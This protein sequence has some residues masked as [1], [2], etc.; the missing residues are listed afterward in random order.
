MENAKSH[1]V[2]Q[3]DREFC[4]SFFF[5]AKI[6]CQMCI[7]L[8][9]QITLV[10]AQRMTR[11]LHTGFPGQVNVRGRLSSTRLIVL[12]STRKFT[13]LHWLL[14]L[15]PLY[16]PPLGYFLAIRIHLLSLPVIS[17]PARSLRHFVYFVLLLWLLSLS[18]W[19]SLSLSLISVSQFLILRFSQTRSQQPHWGETI[20]L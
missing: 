18:F 12:W 10:A 3:S 11:G 15:P 9:L 2:N 17:V 6:S 4:F 13:L 7:V 5:I 16:P 14:F 1:L 8:M 19:V 20:L